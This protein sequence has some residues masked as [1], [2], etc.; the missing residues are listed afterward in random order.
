MPGTT[1][2]DVAPV[3]ERTSRSAWIL[4]PVVGAVLGLSSVAGAAEVPPLLP[5]RTASMAGTHVSCKASET[6]VTCKKV[7]GLTATI[8]MQTG[9]V[10][11][12]RDSWRLTSAS[13]P[14]V[15][16]NNNGFDVLGTKGIGVYCHVYVPSKPTMSCSLDDPLRVHNSHG[17]DMTD[18]SVVVF[19]YDQSGD[20]HNVKTIPQP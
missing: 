16:N 10:H 2:R 4:L 5:G 9:V 18:R 6:F 14:R 11:V 1:T 17:F 19:H 8:V 7:G 3:A 15:L 13:K 12:T 20:R